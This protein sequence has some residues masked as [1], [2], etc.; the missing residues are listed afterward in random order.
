MVILKN[1]TSFFTIKIVSYI[2]Q[3][4]NINNKKLKE[5]K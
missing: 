5:L 3:K 2:K 4:F 1:N